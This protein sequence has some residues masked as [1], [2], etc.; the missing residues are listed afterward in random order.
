LI[1][2]L[3]GTSCGLMYKSGENKFHLSP[4]KIKHLKQKKKLSTTDIFPV[5]DHLK[6][7]DSSIY[8]NNKDDFQYIEVNQ[9]ME[10]DYKRNSNNLFPK[11]SY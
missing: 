8:K 6:L 3:G 1:T 2:T 4:T 11:I 5:L 9:Q 7:P 10:S